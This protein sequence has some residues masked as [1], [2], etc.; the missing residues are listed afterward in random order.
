MKLTILDRTGNYKHEVDYLVDI[1][2]NINFSVEV[3]TIEIVENSRVGKSEEEID[4][5]KKENP[6]YDPD[7]SSGEYYNGVIRL[8]KN[9]F[10]KN[11]PE[12]AYL[13]RASGVLI[14]EIA[15]II[16]N[17]LSSSEKNEWREARKKDVSSGY[18]SKYVEHIEKLDNS[19]SDHIDSED[20][21]DSFRFFVL[22]SSF[23]MNFPHR[24]DFFNKLN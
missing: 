18:V 4:A 11:L 14:H 6:H 20:F 9:A 23:K 12:K 19:H 24:T 22:D 1:F 5:I 3:P 10:D 16:F 7:N 2:S 17:S 21:C 8:F 13:E 15:H